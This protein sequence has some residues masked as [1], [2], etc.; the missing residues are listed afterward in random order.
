MSALR[1]FVAKNLYVRIL[2]SPHWRVGWRRLNGPDLWD[3]QCLRGTRWNVLPDPRTRFFADP[4]AIKHDGRTVLFVEDF[5]HFRQKGVISALEFT[6]AG[7]A[8]PVRRV[9]EEP[10]HLSYPFVMESEGDVWMIP[11]SSANREVAIYRADPFPSKWVKEATLLRDVPANDATVVRHEDRYWLFTTIGT[12]AHASSDLY[13]FSARTLFGPWVA[14]KDNP[15]LRDPRSARSAGR[16]VTRGGRLWRPVQDCG[17]HYG[18]AVGLAEITC[19]S[20]G[21]YQQVVRNV[22][23]PCWEWPGRHLHTLSQAG[24]FEFID[25]SA[26]VLRWP[27]RVVSQPGFF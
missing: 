4:I 10:W 17:P 3:T 9:L 21:A 26:N 12:S 18:A 6:P 25:G 7:P 20:L 2:R 15:V 27:P 5:D 19:L 11:E 13:V 8:G 1:E 24:G 16:T 23:A 14:H 22:L